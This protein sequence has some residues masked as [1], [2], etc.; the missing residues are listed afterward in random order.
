MN[1]L[2]TPEKSINA[3][4]LSIDSASQLLRE[5]SVEIKG[6][7]CRGCKMPNRRVWYGF[8][9][10]LTSWDESHTAFPLESSSALRVQVIRPAVHRLPL[11]FF[12]LYHH[13]KHVRHVAFVVIFVNSASGKTALLASLCLWPLSGVVFQRRKLCA[14]L[15]NAATEMMASVTVGSEKERLLM[16][17]H[18]LVIS[19]KFAYSFSISS[20]SWK[21]SFSTREAEW[22]CVSSHWLS[23][24]GNVSSQIDICILESKMRIKKRQ[25]NVALEVKNWKSFVSTKWKMPRHCLQLTKPCVEYVTLSSDRTMAGLLWNGFSVFVHFWQCGNS[26]WLPNSKRRQCLILAFICCLQD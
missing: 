4:C 9:F 24:S 14:N 19:T 5:T 13:C 22:W 23:N 17:V 21:V 16:T 7:F 12:V 26:S 11:K 6:L 15:A 10:V 25:G 20:S 1:F 2:Q 3:V 18:N 8:T